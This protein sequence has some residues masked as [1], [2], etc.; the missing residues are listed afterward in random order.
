[1]WY[2]SC[3]SSAYIKKYNDCYYWPTCIRYVM[4]YL[5]H[6]NRWHRYIKSCYLMKTAHKITQIVKGLKM[7]YF[8]CHTQRC[9]DGCLWAV[10]TV[11]K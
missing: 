2:G 9:L 6:E 3:D 10:G 5:G 4:L 1:M 11:R 8:E 7:V